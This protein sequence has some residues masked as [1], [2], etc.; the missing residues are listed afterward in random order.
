MSWAYVFELIKNIMITQTGI[1]N[2]AVKEVFRMSRKRGGNPAAALISFMAYP[3]SPHTAVFGKGP[4]R[5]ARQ[6]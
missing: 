3:Q 4:D 5:P 1:P 2:L 6:A